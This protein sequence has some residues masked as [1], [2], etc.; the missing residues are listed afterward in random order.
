M[1][2]M[3]IPVD[4]DLNGR[5]V[6]AWVSPNKTLLE[7]L[8]EDFGATEV[9]YGCGEGVCGTCTV[10]LD[11]QPV[12]SCLIF[13]PQVRN[14]TV[15]TLAGLLDE[16]GGLHPL[17]RS[18]LQHGGS[19]CGFCTPGMVLTAL[20]YAEGGGTADRA[21]IR[22]ALAGNL[23]RCT[24]YTKIVDAVEDYVAGRGDGHAGADG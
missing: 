19:Q 3:P 12:N 4:L 20:H 18:F 21:S 11:G 1:A 2:K 23:C 9:K 6:L 5:R 10:L 15:V 14:R 7:A 17:Q 8:R 16:D 13:A 24:G 22:E